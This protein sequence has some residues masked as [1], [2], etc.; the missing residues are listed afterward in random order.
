MDPGLSTTDLPTIRPPLVPP[1][2]PSD[3]ILGTWLLGTVTRD[4]SGPCYLFTTDDNDTVALYSKAAGSLTAGT[5]LRVLVRAPG[6]REFFDCGGPPVQVL[7]TS[8][9]AG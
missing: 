1:S 7:L 9:P 6:D 2:A 8:K 5:R 3:Q 4:G